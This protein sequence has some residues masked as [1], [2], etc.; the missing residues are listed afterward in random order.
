MKNEITE[1]KRRE[2]DFDKQ[3]HEIK[4]YMYI[5]SYQAFNNFTKASFD[6][7]ISLMNM[8]YF[9]VDNYH[10]K[11]ISTIDK[12]TDVYLRSYFE[13]LF[14]K[15]LQKAKLYNDQLSVVML[16]IDKFK[17]IND[18]Y[19]HRKGDEILTRMCQVIKNNVRE[20]DLIGRYGGEEFVLVF[21]G[22]EKIRPLR[23]V[24]RLER[25]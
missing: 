9:F 3:G 23:F 14:S 10:L 13:D 19:G 22:T 21:P 6:A 7:C 1:I 16:D 17:A 18:T 12:L 15:A 4:G 24:K 2:Q 25:P 11:K 8:L 20:T 5:E